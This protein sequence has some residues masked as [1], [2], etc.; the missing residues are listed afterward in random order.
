L[1]LLK[2][3]GFDWDAKD[4]VVPYVHDA[5]S[6]EQVLE[7]IDA[8]VK[9]YERFGILVD[10]DTE[11]TRRWEQVRGRLR[12]AGIAAPDQADRAGLVIPG[13]SS[14]QR[15][16]VWLMPDNRTAGILEDFL[17]TLVPAGDLIWPHA[18]SSTA[19]ARTLEAPLA[20]KDTMKGV[21]HAWLAWR[22]EP[23]LPFGTA[24]TA[25][26]LGHDS[27]EALAFVTW[28]RR[29]FLDAQGPVMPASAGA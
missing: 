14:K 22:E 23:G 7:G 21:L 27:A 10:A 1:N 18:E 17:A 3:H 20:E 2:R 5:G 13:R 12:S 9:S 28:F 16:G 8:G 25:K 6:V 26:V 4:V 29:L 19:Q 24:L 15:V 11:P